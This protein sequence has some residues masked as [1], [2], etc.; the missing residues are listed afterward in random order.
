V[1][2]LKNAKLRK[3]IEVIN[4]HTDSTNTHGHS[5]HSLSEAIANAVGEAMGELHGDG[6]NQISLTV[7]VDGYEFDGKEYRVS[8]RV[9]MIDYTASQHEL[10]EHLNNDAPNLANDMTAAIYAKRSFDANDDRLAHEMEHY[11]E[12]TFMDDGG[13]DSFTLIAHPFTHNHLEMEAG[14]FERRD[15]HPQNDYKYDAPEPGL[16]GGA[17]GGASNEDTAK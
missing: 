11:L 7:I 12:D 17:S 1:L 14:Y 6:D 15:F 13:I 9:M 4:M 8:V 16:G 10:Y 3:N 5:K 2:E